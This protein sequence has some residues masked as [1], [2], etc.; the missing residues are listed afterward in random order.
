MEQTPLSLDKAKSMAT[1]TALH[2]IIYYTIAL[3]LWGLVFNHFILF[4]LI[5]LVVGILISLISVPV[6]KMQKTVERAN[7]MMFAISSLWGNIGILIG[8][9]GLIAWI[10]KII[11]FR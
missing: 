5:G 7:D 10:V 11:F 6:I 9:V 8:V 4:V 2:L 3:A 1:G